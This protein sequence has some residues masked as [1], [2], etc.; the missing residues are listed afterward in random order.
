M[1]L[2]ARQLASFF[3]SENNMI[4]TIIDRIKRKAEIMRLDAKARQNADTFKLVQDLSEIQSL[5]D[6]LEREIKHES[7]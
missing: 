4:Q 5:C 1:N 2:E 7:K 3:L 6:I